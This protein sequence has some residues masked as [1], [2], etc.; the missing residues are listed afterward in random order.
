MTLKKELQ[1]PSKLIQFSIV[2]PPKEKDDPP[3]FAPA[4]SYPSDAG[5]DLTVS[6]AVSIHPSA[7]G[8]VPFN[9]AVAIPEGHFAFLLGRSS[10]FWSKGLH[11][12]LGVIDAGY[13]GEVEAVVFNPTPRTVTL[14]EGDRPAQLIVLPLA[15]F[16]LFVQ[17]DELPPGER[18]PAGFGST[19][20]FADK[21][22]I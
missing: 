6:R 21:K 14:H 15:Q 16:T 1:D 7:R 19:G 2:R 18:G 8:R 20:G 5:F 13:R 4:K 22:G 12:H 11:V 9:I 3:A 17:A 10:T